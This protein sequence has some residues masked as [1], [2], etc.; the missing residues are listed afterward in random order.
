MILHWL[1]TA[2]R[3]LIANPLFSLITIASL[4]IGCCGA[5]LAGANIKQHLSFE[6]GFADAERIMLVRMQPVAR[7]GSLE[8]QGSNPPQ[9]GEFRYTISP[10]LRPLIDGQ[11]K[12]VLATTRV[13]SLGP[14]LADDLG[15]PTPD[16]VHFVDPEFFNV[17]EYQ[18]L[19][20]NK[21]NAFRTPESIV[22]TQSKAKALFG[23]E[24][25]LGKE[26]K[27]TRRRTWTISA[28]ISDP[29]QPSMS[30]FTALASTSQ[31]FG[32][33]GEVDRWGYTV[34]GGIFL[35]IADDV[36]PKDF[37][38]LAN[39]Q[40]RTA[41]NQGQRARYYTPEAQERTAAAA[42]AGRQV[43]RPE[44]LDVRI[45]LIPITDIHLHPRSATGIDSTGD[46]TMLITLGTAA[47]ALLAVSA[48]NYVVLSLAR[49]LRRRREVGVRKVL[50]ASSGVVARHYLAEAVLVTAISVGIG[51]ALAELLQP[52][53][54]RALDQSELLFNLYDPVFLVACV[55]VLALLALIVGAYP[56]LYL[57]GTRPRAG[58]DA[59]ASQG[60]GRFGRMVTGGLLGLQ[61]MAATVLLS[62]ALTMA[63]QARYVAERPLGFRMEGLYS[64]TSGCGIRSTPQ[65]AS[66]NPDCSALLDRIVRELPEIKRIAY[67]SNAGI[68]ASGAPQPIT[69][70]VGGEK[71]GD[72]FAMAIDL[73]FLD[74]TQA[75]LIA[76]RMFDRNSAYDR[77]ILDI[78]PRLPAEPFEAVPVVVT[79]AMAPVVGAATPEDAV[80][81]R[82]VIGQPRYTKSYEIIGVVEDWHQR[83]L[84]FP[85]APIAFIPGGTFMN[86]I[87]ELDEADMPAVQEKLSPVGGFAA[88]TFGDNPQIVRPKLAELET[89][90]ENTYAGDRRLMF[91][92]TGFA[93]VAILV[94]CLGV[95]GLST[96]EMRRRV[97]EIGIRKALGATPAKVAGAVLGRQMLF[98]LAA[99]MLAW[100][101][102]WWLS[103]EWLNQYA[104]RTSLGLVV[105][106][107]ATLAVV[108]FVT[109]AVGLSAGWASAI[110]PGLALKAAT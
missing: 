5:L 83:S 104:Y 8:A 13:I 79:R 7:P 39:E 75:T 88:G 66:A 58:L 60:N 81:K 31:V 34:G 103:T 74:L 76:G 57:A 93:G 51:F 69:R 53:F 106:P 32:S 48:F 87:V 70:S 50:G 105:L 40:I 37:I 92:V 9:E 94:A 28:V 29:P 25:A 16:V 82:F 90:F 2:W 78:Y 71:L 91:A 77:R 26:L 54:A 73:D 12:G 27:G 68:L 14:V 89:T 98:A 11:I 109:F 38:A 18:F 100:P 63:V 3:S 19:E 61:V 15:E 24:P 59:G 36:D 47:A 6:R 22:I 43:T 72:G 44:D 96:F 67:S 41:Y 62:I 102:A 99:S 1:S 97:R 86:V 110:R 65:Q 35:R 33:V 52:W 42:A 64:I 55:G 49:A 17:F 10:A 95:Y 85:L 108:A 80:G 23:E 56:A 101:I 84:K 45:S 30:T 21:E 46:V 107:V 20:G 4:S